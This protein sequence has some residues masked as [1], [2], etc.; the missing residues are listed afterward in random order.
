VRV[1][2]IERRPFPEEEKK[3]ACRRKR[4]DVVHPNEFFLDRIII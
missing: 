4:D 1:D 2:S 3:E